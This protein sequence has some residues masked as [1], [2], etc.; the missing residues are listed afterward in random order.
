MEHPVHC[1]RCNETGF[2][3]LHQLPADV[4]AQFEQSRKPLPVLAWIDANT[5]HDVQ[6]CDCCGNGENWYGTP[7]QH[8]ASR[9]PTNSGIPECA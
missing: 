7:G 3:N 2:L 4:L 5:E 1:T 8:D 9:H 6:V